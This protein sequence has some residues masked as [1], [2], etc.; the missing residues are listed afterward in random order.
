MK[1]FINYHTTGWSRLDAVLQAASC[2]V[3]VLGAMCLVAALIVLL[4][5]AEVLPK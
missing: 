3:A 1:K 4:E 5:L 2:G